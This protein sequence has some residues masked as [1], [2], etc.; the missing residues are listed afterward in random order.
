MGAARDDGE[1]AVLAN[2]LLQSLRRLAV[3]IIFITT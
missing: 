2:V 3:V 1:L